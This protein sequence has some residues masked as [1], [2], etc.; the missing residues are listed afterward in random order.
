[1]AGRQVVPIKAVP[2]FIRF[3]EKNGYELVVAI[4]SGPQNMLDRRVTIKLTHEQ[5]VKLEEW[6][7]KLAADV[8][9][10]R[11]DL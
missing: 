4:T 7:P 6:E 10:S 5:M 9:I 1:M 2:S 3:T 8:T 11:V